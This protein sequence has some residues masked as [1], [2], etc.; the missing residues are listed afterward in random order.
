MSFVDFEP[1]PQQRPYDLWENPHPQGLIAILK[2][3][4]N[5]IPDLVNGSIAATGAPPSTEEEAFLYNLARD[6]GIAGA[7][8][9]ASTFWSRSAAVCQ[10]CTRCCEPS[11]TSST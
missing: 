8:G 5:M 10:S 11:G 9:A 2:R 3:S 6:R 7:F 4:L 1:K